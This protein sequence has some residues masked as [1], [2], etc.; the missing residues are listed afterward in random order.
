MKNCWFIIAAF[1]LLGVSDITKQWQF[2]LAA[3]IALFCFVMEGLF[4]KNEN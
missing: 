4:H 3:A 2:L 1:T